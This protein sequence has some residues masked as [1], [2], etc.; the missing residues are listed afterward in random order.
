MSTRMNFPTL[1]DCEAAVRMHPNQP[2]NWLQLGLA[3]N[4]AERSDQALKCFEQAT[5]LDPGF[6]EAQYNCGVILY[7]HGQLA[8]AAERYRAA[9]STQPDFILARSNLGVTLEALGD[10]GAALAAYDEAIASDPNN[11]SPYWN[12]ALLQLRN[13]DYAQGW[14]HYEWRWTAG[15]VGGRRSF[16]GKRLWLGGVPL[17]GKTILLHEEQGL[18]DMIQFARFVPQVAALGARVVLQTF[19]PLKALFEGMPGTEAVLDVTEA[20]S[21]FDFYCPLMS[22]PLA[23]GTTLETL[24]WHGPYLGATSARRVLWQKRLGKASRPRIGFVW[25]GNPRHEGDSARSIPL[26][27]FKGVFHEGAE[28]LSL[29]KD[30]TDAERAILDAHGVKHVGHLLAD[31]VD[32]AAVLETCDLVI[33]VDTSIAHLAGAMDKKLWLLLPERSDWRWLKEGETSPW[34]PTARLFR[35]NLQGVWDDVIEKIRAECRAGCG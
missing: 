8:A 19:T 21:K 4:A 20:L 24:P 33:S 23:L 11:P 16:P 26:P 27:V 10:A 15:K 3:Q 35:G 7:H 6:A 5:A 17:A 29:Q 28:F 1:A 30:A 2:Q 31:F 9:L 18:G 22:L 14:R 25:K 12:K 13:G 34:Y 32:T